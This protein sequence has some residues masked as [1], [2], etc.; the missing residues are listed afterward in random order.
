[1]STTTK[2]SEGKLRP[3]N[4][5]RDLPPVADLV[6]LCFQ[7]NMDDEG[8]TYLKEMRSA[9][10]DRRYLKWA[11]TTIPL[12]GYVWETDRKIVGNISIV[13]FRRKKQNIILLA[14][15]AVHPDYRR[16]GIASQLTRKGI[17][18]AQQRGADAL[19]LHVEKDNLGAI[20]LYKKLGF[21]SRFLRTT[22]ICRPATLANRKQKQRGI[23]SRTAHFWNMEKNWLEKS[24]PKEIRWYRMPVWDVFRPGIKHRLYRLF[25]EYDVRAWAIQKNGKPKAVL[26]WH[27]NRTKRAP[28]WLAVSPRA[29]SKSVAA[30]L[31]YVRD[32]ISS[33]KRV[34]TIDYPA[35][36]LVSAFTDARFT[37]QR[38]LVWMKKNLR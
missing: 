25:V 2:I 29:D 6:E 9:G 35:E 18:E 23:T 16:K 22:W 1:M 33:P 26:H 10:K 11:S 32:K 7:K 5:L 28:L 3:L 30:L 37:P 15:I 21:Q 14:N 17:A 31:T 8:K 20:E 34:L 13:P 12:R 4:I 24:Y 27:H 38:T 19:W 36:E